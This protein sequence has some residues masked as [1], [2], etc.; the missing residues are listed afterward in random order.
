ME[1]K[2]NKALVKNNTELLSEMESLLILGGLSGQDKD[3]DNNAFLSNCDNNVY[4]GEANCGNCVSQ[5]GCLTS[6]ENGGV[7]QGGKLP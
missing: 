1:Q 4:C 6:G 2:S 3:K 5:C 7:S